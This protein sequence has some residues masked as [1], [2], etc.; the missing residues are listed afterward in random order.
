M[1]YLVCDKCGGYYKLQEGESPEDFDLTCECGGTLR[2]K[3]LIEDDDSNWKIDFKAL[4]VGLIITYFLAIFS[5]IVGQYSFLSYSAPVIGGFLSSYIADG[6]KIKRAFNSFIVMIIVSITAFI[7][8][9]ILNFNQDFF[10][11]G[12]D[13]IPLIFISLLYFILPFVIIGTFCGY[14]AT[15]I[16][17]MSYETY[18]KSI[19]VVKEHSEISRDVEIEGSY[20]HDKKKEKT[21]LQ[22]LLKIIVIIGGGLILSNILILPVIII[23]INANYLGHW[24]TYVFYMFFGVCIALI[25]GMLWFIFRKE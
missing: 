7:L 8:F 11:G 20:N 1:S 13:F 4:L 21:K 18:K 3:K 10:I 22:P 19:Y 25:L 24:G 17:D 5:Y 14:L 12:L 6:S 23:L 16:K 9:F 2:Y 15:I